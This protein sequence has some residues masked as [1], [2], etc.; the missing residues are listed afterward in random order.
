MTSCP[1]EL[2]IWGFEKKQRVEIRAQRK[3]VDF[4]SRLGETCWDLRNVPHVVGSDG[5]ISIER[6]CV[7]LF[8]CRKTFKLKKVNKSFVPEPISSVFEFLYVYEQSMNICTFHVFVDYG[9]VV[10]TLPTTQNPIF[11]PI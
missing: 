5:K 6:N 9:Y 1:E 2:R 3:V 11:Q 8:S 7:S 4:W 10:Y